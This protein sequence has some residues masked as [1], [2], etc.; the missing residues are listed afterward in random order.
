MK[1]T[2]IILLCLA[3]SI[4]FSQT[5]THRL[6]LD[7]EQVENSADL[8]IG[9]IKWGYYPLTIDTINVHSGNNSAAITSDKNG[10]QFGSI[11]YAIPANYSGKKI[12]LNGFMKYE[13]V[14]DGYVG[15]ILQI[16]RNDNTYA[17][18]DM[19]DQKIVGTNN[20]QEYSLT[21]DLPDSAKNI[22]VA[23]ILSGRGKAW[24]DDFTVTID[25][26][27]I[28]ILEETRIVD[29]S[30]SMSDKTYL[31]VKT[32]GLLKYYSPY[33]YRKHIDW[34]QLLLDNYVS[35]QNAKNSVMLNEVLS[36]FIDPVYKHT[37]I[38]NKISDEIL[39]YFELNELEKIDNFSFLNDT[40]KYVRKPDFSW[41]VNQPLISDENQI[42]LVEI[43]INYKPSK[44]KYIKEIRE[45]VLKPIEKDYSDVAFYDSLT[46]TIPEE[47]RFLTLARYW[48]II[49]YLYPY[50]SLIDY[51]WDNYL[52]N[53]ASYYMGRYYLHQVSQYTKLLDDGHA[54]TRF[55]NTKKTSANN[56]LPQ[57]TKDLC[58]PFNVKYLNG[59][60]YVHNFIDTSL[61]EKS[62]IKSGDKIISLNKTE[63]YKYLRRI[64]Y[65]SFAN[66]SA[67]RS[68][69]EARYPT[70]NKTD[71]IF[72]VSILRN[73]DSLQL[74]CLGIPKSKITAI[75]NNFD[76][77]FIINDSTTY[78]T[79]A[80]P[81]L[82]FVDLLKNNI[83]KNIIL[84]L[85][86]YPADLNSLCLL[87]FLSKDTVEFAKFYYPDIEHPGVFIRNE[88]SMH[89]KIEKK[90]VPK[91]YRVKD[92]DCF[93]NKMFPKTFSKKLVVL[94]DGSS[95]SQSET[96]CMLIKAYYP[97]AFFVG[98]H[99]AGS[100]GDMVS[101]INLP[102]GASFSYSSIDFHYP[103]GDQLQ[104]I[105]I[106]P[107]IEVNSTIE[108]IKL[109][110][111]EI[112]EMG[113]KVINK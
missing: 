46:L 45:S 23:G 89:Y 33:V 10:Y 26:Q 70:W 97:D 61:C 78:I 64:N 105:G 90:E 52:S 53:K 37:K 99:T 93:S 32:W 86:D 106:I 62:G 102:G 109:G 74:T 40:N 85:R 36:R 107:D 84:D 60:L 104:R 24:F 49:N 3:N 44:T 48:N 96:V 21:L 4:C 15:L 19:Q 71:S 1:K 12:T 6:N 91:S 66:E 80:T 39:K 17:F 25:G 72:E 51:D 47:Y 103:N 8:P 92:C 57:K 108:S 67:F 43:L 100:N 42:K 29:S 73:K 50:K 75:N 41:I 87:E 11:A 7:F 112:L 82:E 16:E 68:L 38:R 110:N 35:I 27:D 95:I 54:Y 81:G 18:Q 83:E 30:L 56:R 94:I 13:N 34:D 113:I 28:Q 20:W 79:V 65:S 31:F 22:Y 55:T 88:E 77:S 2:L 63:T 111:D 5:G 9:W 76:N 101:G 58:V 98:H 59:N 69:V 14:S